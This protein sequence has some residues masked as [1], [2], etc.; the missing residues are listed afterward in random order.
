M[1]LTEDEAKQQWCPHARV[2]EVG[3]GELYGPFN[4]YHTSEQ[5]GPTDSGNE[6]RCIASQ[7]MAWRWAR[8]HINDPQNLGGDMIPS[9][10]A[11]G[12]CGAFGV[13]KE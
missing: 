9:T 10:R 4:R 13:P 12:Y 3:D 1:Y 11:Y 7:C 6:A 8:T 2:C 5:S